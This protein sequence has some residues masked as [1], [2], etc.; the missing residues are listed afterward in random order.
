MNNNEIELIIKN[1]FLIMM[2]IHKKF[3]K[4]DACESHDNF[5]RLHYAV[6]GNLSQSDMTMSALAKALMMPKPQLTRLV[7]SLVRLD[8]VE[9]RMNTA[10]RRVITLVLTD[11]GKGILKEMRL[12]MQKNTKQILIGLTPEDLKKMSA[13][14]DS[15]QDTL[16]KL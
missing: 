3:L 10:D 5:T 2:T 13:A 9:R 12:R 8:L 6:M 1:M 16:S 11:K 15:L 7:D 14:L 4:M